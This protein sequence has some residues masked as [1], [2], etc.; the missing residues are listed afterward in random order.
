MEGSGCRVPH[1]TGVPF[2]D[3]GLVHVGQRLRVP[4]IAPLPNAPLGHGELLTDTHGSANS[5]E[6]RDGR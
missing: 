3:H 1:N 2:E 5:N 6:I 4:G